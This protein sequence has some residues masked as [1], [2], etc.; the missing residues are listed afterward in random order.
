MASIIEVT[1][2]PAA[3]VMVVFGSSSPPAATERTEAEDHRTRGWIQVQSV[4]EWSQDPLLITVTAGAACVAFWCSNRGTLRGAAP[5]FVGN[6]ETTVAPFRGVSRLFITVR[7]QNKP[8]PFSFLPS[9]RK[10]TSTY[11]R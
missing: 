5:S 4:Y 10:R 1:K 7:Y 8:S 11:G 9:Y 6:R 2:E 3:M